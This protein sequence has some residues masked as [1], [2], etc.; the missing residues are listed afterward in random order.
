[1]KIRK[2]LVANRGE[3]ALRIMRTSKELGIA[4]VAVYSDPDR[5]ALHVRYAD[6]A[7][8]LSGASP[9]QTY[10]NADKIFDV[11]RRAGADAIHPGYGFF[12]ENAGFARAAIEAGL[13]WIG[14]H[15]DAIDAMGDKLRARAAMVKAKVPVVPGDLKP[16][17]DVT[18]ARRAADEFGLPLALKAAAGG[19][20][21]GLK[22]ART[23][24]EIESAFTTAR[25]EAEAY[26]K[27]GTIYAERYLDNPKHVELQ[28][29]ADKHGNVVHVGERDCSLQR[30]HQKLWEE[31]PASITD[32]VRKRMREAGLR[33]ARAIGYDSAGTIECLVAGNDFFF[34]EMNT[35]IQVEHT[36]SEMV[37]G[38]DLV[39]EQIRVACGEKLGYDQDGIELRGHSIEVRIN[40][41]DPASGFAPSPGTIV[42]YR[43]PG[44]PGVRVDSAAFEGMTITPDYDSLIAK[45]VVWAPTRHRARERLQRALHEFRVE[46]VAT[47]IPL[48]LALENEPSVR[49]ASYGTA[50]LEAFAA[51]A[52]LA[53]QEAQANAAAS[54]PQ[55]GNVVR[56]EVNDKL[57]RVRLL[58]RPA[59]TTSSAQ[60]RRPPRLQARQ[61][62]SGVN[63]YAIVA[64]MHG[65]IAEINAKP[66]DRIEA[67]AVVA[68]IEA[69]KMMNEIRSPHA[70]TVAEVSA[71]VGQ[72][73]EAGAVLLSFERAV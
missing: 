17:A 32:S 35:R 26:F 15:P 10:L 48:L 65:V 33:A 24:D 28:I 38:L 2:L 37:S 23:L 49:D 25:R 9:S 41:E 45:L 51:G 3:I 73:V 29:L 31:T 47:T 64:P 39:G 68:I 56:V 72:T 44:G 58:D 53:P 67:G 7:F 42:R 16:V 8:A 43:E 69:M 61:A 1:M 36:V 40:A 63:E 34:L 22:V 59:A 11:A 62:K 4:T 57:F 66:Q 6:E 60:S 52:A 18:A 30:R 46:G 21:K 5:D 27:D 55:D 19:G 20:G 13:L 50:T 14:P 12:A 70:G 54:A 71:A